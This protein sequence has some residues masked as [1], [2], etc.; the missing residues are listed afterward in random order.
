[1]QRFRYCRDPLFFV[2]CVAY[3]INRWL[4]KPH[5]SNGFFHGYFND[6]WLIPCAL[7]P[8]LWLHRRLGLRRNDNHPQISE[9]SLHLI[10]W[11]V[12]FEYI[13]PKF[14]PH[15]VGDPLD[16]LAYTVGA[17]VAGTWWNRQRFV[18]RV[19]AA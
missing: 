14:M 6:L 4:L 8:I 10:F 13:G 15:T 16:V 3:A 11:S 18:S 19:A 5:T 7:P 17:L 2:G 1:M 9:I 12:L